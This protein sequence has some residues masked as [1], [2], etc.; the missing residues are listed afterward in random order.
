VEDGAIADGLEL[1]ADCGDT[2]T[3]RSSNKVFL[4]KKR[5][6]MGLDRL[7]DGVADSCVV[8]PASTALV[9]GEAAAPAAD[10]SAAASTAAAGGAGAQVLPGCSLPPRSVV[11]CGSFNPLH[12]GHEA[13][14]DAAV[15]TAQHEMGLVGDEVSGLVPVLEMSVTNADKGCIDSP[16]VRRRV[17]QIAGPIRTMS[18]GSAAEAGGLPL[19][20]QYPA[21]VTGVSGQ[22]WPMLLTHEPFF[23]D[24]AQF[25]RDCWIVIGYDT[26]IRL[27]DPKYFGG[28][29]SGVVRA[30]TRIQ[31]A[32]CRLLVASRAANATT[33]TGAPLQL[34]GEWHRTC[35]SEMR[36]AATIGF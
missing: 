28:S 17:E 14:L 32:G 21:A 8:L 9:S 2:A 27:C 35:Q 20:E 5:V 18:E 33:G 7:L 16:T 30:M 12:G 19:R 26:A 24:K 36:N 3:E 31:D 1:I 11:L 25:M 22:L 34:D 4:G 23:P 10:D 13:L 29:A 6:E 15:A